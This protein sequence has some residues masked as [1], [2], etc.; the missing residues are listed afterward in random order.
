MSIL[1]EN[2]YQA[3]ID[4]A[5]IDKNRRIADGVVM[6]PE[7]K[8]NDFDGENY[9]IS[10][11]IVS[12]P[13]NATIPGGIL[14]LSTPAKEIFIFAHIPKT[15][16]QTLRNCFMRHLQ[17]H[18]EFIHLGPYGEKDAAARGLPPFA[19]RSADERAQA[20]VILGHHVTC[21]THRFVP[22]KTP[23]QSRF[24]ATRPICSCRITITCEAIA[25]PII[26]K[27]ARGDIAAISIAQNQ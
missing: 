2:F 27:Q 20:R 26:A 19:K 21:E 25:R 17:L 14:D 22:N 6:T 15:D 1:R 10:D 11:G 24:C 5:I 4:R 12:V 18:R 16:G 7:G 13:K 8:R 23:R 3:V 9:F